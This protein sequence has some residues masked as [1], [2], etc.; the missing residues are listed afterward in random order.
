MKRSSEDVHGI[1]T[2]FTAHHTRFLSFLRALAA[3]LRE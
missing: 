2:D 1:A 3:E